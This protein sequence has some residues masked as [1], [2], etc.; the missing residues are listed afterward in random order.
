MKTSDSKSDDD[1]DEK[2]RIARRILA[3]LRAAG[4]GAYVVE[5]VD[6]A[7]PIIPVLPASLKT[8]WLA[9]PFTKA[10]AWR[11]PLVVIFAALLV[12]VP[13]RVGIWAVAFAWMGA[14]CVLNYRRCGRI[15]CRYTGPYYLAMIV[16][17]LA[18]GIAPVLIPITGWLAIAVAIPIGSKLIWWATE[19]AWGKFSLS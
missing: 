15:H 13:A 12:P 2:A 4:V 5:D 11:L 14:A 17:V 10:L 6:D 16:P 3:A 1:E 9:D 8:D 7:P 18:L 19:R